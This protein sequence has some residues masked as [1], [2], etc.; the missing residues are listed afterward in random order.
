MHTLIKNIYVAPCSIAVVQDE[1][2]LGQLPI[3]HPFGELRDG[4]R[5]A[6]L[7]VEHQ[8]PLESCAGAIAMRGEYRLT[9]ASGADKP[10]RM[11]FVPCIG[12]RSRE[13][14]QL[15]LSGLRAFVLS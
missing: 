1:L 14:G 12:L 6:V 4:F 15:N 5:V 10:A 9:A 3:A 7:V 8:E 13:S 11:E 2:V